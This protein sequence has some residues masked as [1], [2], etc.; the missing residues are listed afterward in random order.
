MPDRSAE[1]FEG[2]LWCHQVLEALD[3]YVDGWLSDER[4]GAVDVHLASCGRCERFGGA[5]AATVTSIR[6]RLGQAPEPIDE[7]VDARLAQRL[8][9]EIGE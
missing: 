9:R 4:R 5:Y 7:G 2:G 1:A 3:G 6:R 8:A